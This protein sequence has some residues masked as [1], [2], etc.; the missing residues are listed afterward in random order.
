MSLLLNSYRR[1]VSEDED[2][3]YNDPWVILA[4]VL[5]AALVF[6][7]LCRLFSKYCVEVSLDKNA[8][9]QK[10]GIKAIPSNNV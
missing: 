6:V 1:R 4:F 2:F 8:L 3:G 10:L 9:K 7:M 5:L